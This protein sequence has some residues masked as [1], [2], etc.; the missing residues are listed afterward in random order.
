MEEQVG[1]EDGKKDSTVLIEAL[2]DG[3]EH[4]PV[5]DTI[6]K[7]D[8]VLRD[9]ESES[10][11]GKKLLDEAME[12]IK[13]YP[14][15]NMKSQLILPWQ[16]RTR[17]PVTAAVKREQ[18][19]RS[20]RRLRQSHLAL[21]SEHKRTRFFEVYRRKFKK[22]LYNERADKANDL[23]IV[24]D[25]LRSRKSAEMDRP[26]APPPVPTSGYN[27]WMGQ[28]KF[29][30]M[31]LR[32]K[33]ESDD[34]RPSSPSQMYEDDLMPNFINDQENKAS[35]AEMGKLWRSEVP[36]QEKRY[37]SVICVE[38]RKDIALQ[39]QQYAATG[40][41]EKSKRFDHFSFESDG[42]KK[43]VW[44]RKQGAG[45]GLERW[46][47]NHFKSEGFLRAQKEREKKAAAAITSNASQKTGV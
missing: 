18:S 10:G 33:Q 11:D 3:N 9:F 36:E 23:A 8:D 13:G 7:C 30:L 43:G 15:L 12:L 24:L 20:K 47:R 44:M 14:D 35:A 16:L 39:F 21:Q 42:S 17:G 2:S 31:H 40:K 37:Y 29:K 28:M 26:G 32:G 27:I 5:Y 19:M 41:Y 38:I 6:K 4:D 1:S 34:G 25:N 45:N 46:L 22:R